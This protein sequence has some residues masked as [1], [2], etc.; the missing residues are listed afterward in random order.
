MLVRWLP[1]FAI[2]ACSVSAQ[3]LDYPTPGIPRTKDGKPNLT[4]PAPKA[5]DGKPDLT[6]I[7]LRVKPKSAPGGP[8]FGN[9]V[10]Y[11]M[12]P[13]GAKVPFQ[14]WA[15]ALLNKRRFDDLGADR[16]SEHCLPHGVIGGMLPTVPF[17]IL[18]STGV[19]TILFEQLNHY[20]QIFTDGRGFPKDLQPAWYGYSIGKWEGDT[21]VVSTAGYND[22]TWLD[23]SGHPHTEAMRTT[24]RFHRVDFGHLDLQITV[25]DPKAYT[26]PWSVMLHLALMPD[27]E[28]IE[29]VCDNEKDARHAVGK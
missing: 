6:G 2:A 5:A 29:D 1:M 28:L 12:Y 23:D 17:K 18:H 9:T 8:E 16:P 7:W 19:T 24:E 25:D 27:T 21:F 26:A 3:W 20:R 4:A 10:T 13:E 11:Y 14:P 15:E 22:K